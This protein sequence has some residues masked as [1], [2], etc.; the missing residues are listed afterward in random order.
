VDANEAGTGSEMQ[1]QIDMLREQ[2]AALRQDMAALGTRADAGDTRQDAGE[3]RER[4]VTSRVDAIEALATKDSLRI[5]DLEEHVDIDREMILELHEAGV[6]TQ[7]QVQHLQIALRTSRIIG[8]AIGI[9]MTRRF[10]TQDEAFNLLRRASQNTN[11]KLREIAQDIALTG[12]A[13][14]LV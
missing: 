12:D 7:D 11:R 10:V 1:Q 8:Q 13:A 2:L 5:D 3:A 14:A 6:L 4:T 9:V